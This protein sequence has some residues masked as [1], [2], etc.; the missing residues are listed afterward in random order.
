[1]SNLDMESIDVMVPTSFESDGLELGKSIDS[2]ENK[3]SIPCVVA[4]YF[5]ESRRFRAIANALYLLSFIMTLTFCVFVVMPE[6][7]D[8][9]AKMS[10]LGP[11]TNTPFAEIPPTHSFANWAFKGLAPWGKYGSHSGGFRSETFVYKTGFPAS[12]KFDDCDFGSRSYRPYLELEVHYPDSPSDGRLPPILFH[13]H[14]GGWTTG[15]MSTSAWS[16]SYF[17]DRGFAIVSAQYSLACY[18]YSALEMLDDLKS[19]FYYVQ[20][21]AA[22]WGFDASRVHFVGGSAGGHLALLTAYNLNQ[23]SVRSVFNLYGVTDWTDFLSCKDQGT[24]TSGYGGGLA[25]TLANRSCTREALEAISPVH[26]VDA[27]TPLTVTFHGT[28]DS[29]VPFKQAK[30]LHDAL[31]ANSVPNVLVPLETFDHVPEVGYH[32]ITAQMHR[33]VFM[34]LLTI[35]AIPNTTF[36]PRCSIDT[37]ILADFEVAEVLNLTDGN[38]KRCASVVAPV[39]HESLPVLF[40]FHGAGGNAA[41]FPSFRDASGLSWGDMAKKFGF[42]VVGGE[43]IQWSSGTPSPSPVP[44][45]CTACFESAGCHS[46]SDC[47]TCCEENQHTCSSICGPEGVPFSSAVKSVCDETDASFQWHGGEWLIPEVQTD[48]TGLLCDNATY[49]ED[50]AYVRNVLKALEGDDTYDTSRVF[51]TGCSMGSAFTIWI[52]QCLHRDDGSR[53]SAFAT[54][55][56]GLKVKGDGLNFPPDNYNEGATSW[57]ECDACQYFPAPVVA[58]P[59]LKA[60]VVDQTEDPSESDPYFYKSSVAL[61]SAWRKA[62]SRVNASYHSGAHCATHSLEWIVECLDDG[63]GRLIT[64]SA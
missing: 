10:T 11:S 17:L 26:Y 34:R 15:D 35:A 8:L 12:P 45:D 6:A 13:T 51:F 33:Y 62:G 20:A 32:G 57:G 5:V 30:R 59:T 29:L 60:C 61:E 21:N 47:E 56:T 64:E 41:H 38:H 40:V 46:G 54:Q 63:T 4:Q 16:F 52:S 27:A 14:G 43:A 31:D 22:S 1:M 50:L 25:F 49:T 55:S 18:G 3:G 39:A 44:Q 36:P 19:A 48:T 53:I 28:L 37:S 58:S 7:Y 24:S 9:N 42:A 23:S 2:S